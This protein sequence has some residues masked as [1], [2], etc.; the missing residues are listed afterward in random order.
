MQTNKATIATAQQ[1]NN[2]AAMRQ[3]LFTWM[4]LAMLLAI[5]LA[6]SIMNTRVWEERAVACERASRP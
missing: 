2:A 5:A 3:P 4:T 1:I 6:M